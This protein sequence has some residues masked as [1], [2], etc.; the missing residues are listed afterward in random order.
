MCGSAHWNTRSGRLLPILAA[1]CWAAALGGGACAAPGNGPRKDASGTL[2]SAGGQH[3]TAAEL[4]E[5]TRA[6]AD[7]Y[8]GL[9]SSTCDAL[10]KDNPDPV[11]RREA[12]DLLLNCATNVYDIASNPDAFTRML[13]LVVVTTLESQVWIDDD[14]TGEVFGERGEV[15]VRALHHGRVEAWALAGQVL[16]PD[17][18]DLLDY[19]IWDWRR[20]NPDMVRA[21]FVRFSNFAVGR[22][23]SA[24]AEAL[25]AGGFF[26][27]QGQAYKAVDE[28]RRLTERM[29]YLAKREPTLLRWEAEAVQDE[30]LATP[31]IGDALTDV[32]R[33]TAV[34]EQLPKNIAAERK[35]I[36]ATVDD[37]MKAVEG[38][39]ATVRQTVTEANE[40]AATLPETAQSLNTMLKTADALL[41]RYD[42]RQRMA[43]SRPFDVREYT[44]GVKELGAALTQMNDLLKS[45]NEL[46][47]S[48]DWAR[49]IEQVNE[50]ADGR[51]KIASQ[52]SEALVD[53]VFRRVY[54][55]IGAFFG[56][57]ILYRLFTLL[58]SRRLRTVAIDAT[59]LQKGNGHEPPPAA[60]ET[61]RRARL[62][63]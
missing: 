4:D 18:L 46:L 3:I 22:G 59:E 55:T 1:L 40:A 41:A 61:G 47:G 6:F 35:A 42:S 2:G 63:K 24:A 23:K 39:V 14:R 54:L 12:Q 27:P 58:L 49:R 62:S 37:H 45:S 57:L 51:M 30:A 11:Q 33:L 50:S 34:A 32:H 10:K 19:T 21:P 48:S 8:V 29:F 53:V 36:V 15:L 26:D 16:R 43:T 56:L 17:Q 28:A 25:A 38:T 44:Q 5:L 31:E 52:R 7:R 60:S 13:D 9:L 20:H